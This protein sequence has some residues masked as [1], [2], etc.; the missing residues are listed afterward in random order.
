[1]QLPRF[2]I[3]REIIY[4]V[5]RGVNST[6]TTMVLKTLDFKAIDRVPFGMEVENIKRLGMIIILH[7][8]NF[9]CSGHFNCVTANSVE[10]GKPDKKKQH[11]INDVKENL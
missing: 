5:Y 6:T 8:N 1:M 3:K 11:N 7:Q 10:A 4:M 2:H 9:T